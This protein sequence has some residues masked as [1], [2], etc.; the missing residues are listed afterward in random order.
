MK[1]SRVKVSLLVSA[2]MSVILVGCSATA[3]PPAPT[4]T[5]ASTASCPPA[6]G[7]AERT[8]TFSAAPPLCITPTNTYVATVT[9]D[10]GTFEITLDAQKAPN[11][12]NNFVFLARNRYFDGIVFHRVIEGFM[13]QTGDPTGT[14]RGG[15]GYTFADELPAAGGYRIGSVAMANAGADTNGSQFFIVTGESGTSL[16][17]DYSLFGQVTAGLDVVRAIEADGGDPR[18]NGV[19]PRVTHTITSVVIVER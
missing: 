14:G 5:P 16:P 19:P 11:T 17:P 6:S 3:P 10:V 2:L 7:T 12:V 13:A 8:T 18:G 1:S 15:P 4:A 9:T